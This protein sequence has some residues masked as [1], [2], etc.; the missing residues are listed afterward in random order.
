MIP[1]DRVMDVSEERHVE[2]ILGADGSEIRLGCGSEQYTE[3]EI[4]VKGLS[5]MSLAVP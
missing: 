5:W 2:S 3:R 4:D 1:K